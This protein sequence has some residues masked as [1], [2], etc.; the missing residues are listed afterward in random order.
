MDGISLSDDGRH[1]RIIA[2]P[3]WESLTERE[4]RNITRNV[5]LDLARVRRR[6]SLTGLV[7]SSVTERPGNHIPRSPADA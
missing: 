7:T 1:V 6:F 3:A 5:R 2:S 4:Q